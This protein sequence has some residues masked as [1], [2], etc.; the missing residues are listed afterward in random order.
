MNRQFLLKVILFS[1]IHGGRIA[2]TIGMMTGMIVR[3]VVRRKVAS[4]TTSATANRIIGAT[5]MIRLD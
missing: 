5:M 3:I 1:L 4:G 2:V